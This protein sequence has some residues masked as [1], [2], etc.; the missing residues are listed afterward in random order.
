MKEGHACSESVWEKYAK[1]E[2][3]GEGVFNRQLHTPVTLPMIDNFQLQAIWQNVCV[4]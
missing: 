4:S 1:N 3:I 2:K